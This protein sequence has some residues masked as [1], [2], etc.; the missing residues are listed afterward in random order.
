MDVIDIKTNHRVIPAQAGI[1]AEGH[2]GAGCL[3]ITTDMDPGL[4]RDDIVV[5]AIEVPRPR[6]STGSP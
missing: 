1:H 4:R 2:P 5:V 3:R 6:G